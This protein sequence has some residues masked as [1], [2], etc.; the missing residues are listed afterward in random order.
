MRERYGSIRDAGAEAVVVLCQKRTAI[1]AW[2]ESRPVPF[3]VVADEGREIS[4]LWGVYVRWNLESLN[5]ARPASFVVDGRGVVRF[6]HVSRHQ[7]DVP[8]LDDLVAALPP[9]RG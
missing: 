1:A 4:K 7:L 2:L 8:D 3:P 5:I 9:A 6:A